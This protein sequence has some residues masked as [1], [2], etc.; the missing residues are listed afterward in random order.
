M[1]VFTFGIVVT[2]VVTVIEP[3]TGAGTTVRLSVVVSVVVGPA[4]FADPQPAA[5]KPRTARSA[6]S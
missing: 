4:F 2:P 6:S 5:A 3:D 1:P